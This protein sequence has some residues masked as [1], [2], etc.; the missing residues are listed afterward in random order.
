MPALTPSYPLPP[1]IAA[2]DARIWAMVTAELSRTGNGSPRV[3]EL[4]GRIRA[5]RLNLLATKAPNSLRAYNADLSDFQTWCHENQLIPLPAT[6]ETIVR[7]LLSLLDRGLKPSTVLRRRAAI[8]IAHSLSSSPRDASSDQ[9]VQRLAHLLRR[10]PRAGPAKA[11]L[12][13]ADLRRMVGAT[14]RRSRAG[15][16]DRALLLLGFAGA[17]RPSEL[18][19]LDVADIGV[20]DQELHVRVRSQ[21]TNPLRRDRVFD[22]PYGA[23]AETCPVRALRAWYAVSRIDR[24]AVFR[25]VS[26]RGRIGTTRLTVRAVAPIVKRAAQRAGLNP[27]LYAGGSLRAG[28]IRAAAEGGA[29]ERAIMAQTGLRSVAPLRRYAMAWSAVDRDAAGYLGL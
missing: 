18:V 6:A 5:L 13:T 15:V 22:I 14:S 10:Y 7:Y 8:A 25:P 26:R 17:L 19:A 21:S 11:A 28:F 16:R 2:L 12:G 27:R 24:G 3:V 23:H 4:E 29:P 9:V 1:W 20:S